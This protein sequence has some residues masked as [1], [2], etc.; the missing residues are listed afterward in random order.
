MPN[1]L[2]THMLLLNETSILL[3]VLGNKSMETLKKIFFLICPI[4]G[5][6]LRSL[7]FFDV[8]I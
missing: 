7:D 2:S 8:D 1:T 6:N 4:K 5:R 3:V